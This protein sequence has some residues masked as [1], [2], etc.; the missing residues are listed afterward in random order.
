MNARVG[1]GTFRGGDGSCETTGSYAGGNGWV[2]LG[3][4]GTWRG[5]FFDNS[6]YAYS[7]DGNPYEGSQV[8]AHVIGD[9]GHDGVSLNSGVYHAPDR[10]PPYC[11]VA[12]I[13]EKGEEQDGLRVDCPAHVEVPVILGALP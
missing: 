11:Y 3:V 4:G 8:A 10:D 5:L 1:L 6:C 7:H 12:Q 13:D 2:F 9:S